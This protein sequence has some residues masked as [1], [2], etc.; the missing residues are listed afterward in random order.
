MISCAVE[1]SSKAYADKSLEMRSVSAMVF[2]EFRLIISDLTVLYFVKSFLQDKH[3]YQE[4][5]LLWNDELK[6]HSKTP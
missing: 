4:L 1:E 2:I 3:N 6:M 5:A